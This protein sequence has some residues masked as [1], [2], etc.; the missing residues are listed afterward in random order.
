MADLLKLDNFPELNLKEK[1]ELSADVAAAATTFTVK[2]ASGLVD[3]DTD[4]DILV[5]GP[6]GHEACEKRTIDTISGSTITV[7]ALSFAHKKYT[8]V[9]SL[10]GDQIKIYRAANVDGTKPADASFSLLTTVTIEVDQHYTEY[11]DATGGSDYWYKQTFYHSL[12]EVETALAD[13]EAVR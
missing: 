6:P 11:K 2:N 1:T 10:R 13:S 3:T 7:A 4:E 5:I 9:A 8:K 12:Q